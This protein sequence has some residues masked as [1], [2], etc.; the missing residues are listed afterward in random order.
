M[1]LTNPDSFGFSDDPEA[2]LWNARAVFFTGVTLC[3]VF[4]TLYVHY[5][6]DPRMSDWARKEAE[7]L[8]KL[9]EAQGL[10]CIPPNYYDPDNLVLPDDD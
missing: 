4:G 2:D 9:R 6:P 8:V 3:L 7:R 5:I 10:P 1:Y